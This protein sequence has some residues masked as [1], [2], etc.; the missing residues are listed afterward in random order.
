MHVEVFPDICWVCFVPSKIN[1]GNLSEAP[2]SCTPNYS[3]LNIQIPFYSGTYVDV[4]TGH[5]LYVDISTK[6]FERLWTS[7]SVHIKSKH[8]IKVYIHGCIDIIITHNVFL[9]Y[10]FQIPIRFGAI[11]D[12][13]LGCVFC[14]AHELLEVAHRQPYLHLIE[15]WQMRMDTCKDQEESIKFNI[16]YCQLMYDITSIIVVAKFTHSIGR[17]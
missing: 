10:K 12:K 3:I 16:C 13:F 5:I 15:E 11:N 14:F 4:Y 7:W 9:D 17:F 8:V 2:L 1:G 6:R